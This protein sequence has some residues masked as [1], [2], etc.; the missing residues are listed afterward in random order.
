MQ[1]NIFLMTLAHL[2]NDINTGAF[3]A[4]LPFFVTNCGMDYKSI[5]G[6]MFAS[7]FLSSVVQPLFG[8]ISDRSSKKWFIG[9]GVLISGLS[10]AVTGFLENYWLIFLAVTLMGIG[11]SIFH[12]EA[13]RIVNAISGKQR[14]S[15]MGIFSVG[16]NA[17]FGLGP[18]LMVALIS[19][20]G[21]KGTL[22][23]GIVAA[24]MGSLLLVLMPRIKAQPLPEPPINASGSSQQG[25]AIFDV[26][27]KNDWRSFGRLTLVITF[28][29][30]VFAGLSSF[31]P[32]F[33]I[34]A[35][36]TSNAVGTTVLSVLSIA[37]IAATLIGGWLSDRWGYVSVLRYG[38]VLLVPLLAII[39]Y[40]ENIFLV[41]VMLIPLSLAM[42][43]PYSSMVV[44]GQTYLSKNI[45]FA[46]GV[47]LG[48]SISIGGAFQPAL[49][50]FADS[51]GIVAVMTLL[52]AISIAC[53]LCTFLLKKHT[54]I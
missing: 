34:Q 37:G 12:P 18:L 26:H 23:F 27:E 53:A 45:G 21:M 15:A 36:H 8:Y 4:I 16:G 38:C 11:S 19:F 49:G 50:W 44:L 20:F 13:A 9:G 6:L 28:R 54:T 48:L 5:T 39:V 1:K 24:L 41:Y 14:G 3:P 30:V 35:L 52:V 29:S 2:S 22:F 43:G 25:P 31:L 47:T 51:Y 10:L 17:G 46:S 42:Q 32:L 7:C 40:G 33:C